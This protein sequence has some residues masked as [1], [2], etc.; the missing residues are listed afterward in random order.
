MHVVALEMH[1]NKKITG[2]FS[3]CELELSSKL[4]AQK[5][6]DSIHFQRNTLV[7][8]LLLH[9]PSVRSDLFDFIIPL[10]IF[11]S[12]LHTSLHKNELSK[13]K[14]YGP[15]KTQYYDVEMHS[16]FIYRITS[17]FIKFQRRHSY[18][19]ELTLVYWAYENMRNR[20]SEWHC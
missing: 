12:Y 3:F 7:P 20:Q 14:C 8:P 5:R 6:L 2:N 17:V 9:S 11:C 4:I 1:N 18:A 10:F 19:F 13:R 15:W 16:H